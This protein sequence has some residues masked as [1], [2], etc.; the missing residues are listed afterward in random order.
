MKDIELVEVRVVKTRETSDLE[1]LARR[2]VDDEINHPGLEP[3]FAFMPEA[4]ARLRTLL[5]VERLRRGVR[6]PRS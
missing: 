3:I 4:M 6:N 2:I 1:A 5:A